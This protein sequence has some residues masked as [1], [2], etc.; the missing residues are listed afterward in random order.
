MSAAGFDGCVRENAYLL[1]LFDKHEQIKTVVGWVDLCDPA[2]GDELDRWADHAGFAGVRH[3]L[4]DEPDDTYLLRP[5][6]QRGIRMLAPKGLAVRV[7]RRAASCRVR[8]AARRRT[9]RSALFRMCA[10]TSA[11]RLIALAS[12]ENVSCRLSDLDLMAMWHAW[13]P[14]QFVPFFDVPASVRA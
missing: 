8:C 2:V 5:D 9:P 13:S 14:A 6:F 3:V 7:A 1:D 10:G 4:I 12:F 11:D